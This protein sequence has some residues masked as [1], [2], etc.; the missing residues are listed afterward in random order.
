MALTE[1]QEQG[2]VIVG[3]G[4]AAQ[5]CAETL[6]RV[7]YEGRIRIVCGEPRAPYDR[8]PLSKDLLADPAAAQRVAF[9]PPEWYAE[10]EVELLLDTRAGGLDAAGRRLLLESGAQLRYRHLVIATGAAPRTLPA[11]AGRG[12][13]AT[14]RTLEDSLALRERLAGG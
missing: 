12:N 6:R 9:R 7:G 10:K 4:L 3:G 11:F 5:R 13:V 2:V 1:E 14:L 8:P